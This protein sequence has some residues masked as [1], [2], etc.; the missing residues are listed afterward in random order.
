VRLWLRHRTQHGDRFI[1]CPLPSGPAI[2]QLDRTKRVLAAE[3]GTTSETL[4]RTLAKFRDQKTA[5]RQRQHDH[6]NEAARSA[7]PSAKQS[8]RVV[9]SLAQLRLW[10]TLS[11]FHGQHSVQ[12][13]IKSCCE[14]LGSFT[15]E[16][17]ARLT[18]TSAM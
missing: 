4:S 13:R 9:V 16:N 3:M 11:V 15:E 17:S 8:R 14:A 18:V 12:L 10:M 2:V 6:P 7:T 1:R 5:P